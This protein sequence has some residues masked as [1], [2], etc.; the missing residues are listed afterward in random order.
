MQHPRSASNTT[1]RMRSLPPA[2]IRWR[3]TV[4][5][6]AFCINGVRKTIRMSFQ[7]VDQRFDLFL[8]CQPRGYLDSARL[9]CECVPKKLKG[10]P[11]KKIAQ[12]SRNNCEVNG[13]GSTQEWTNRTLIGHEPLMCS[14]MCLTR[15]ELVR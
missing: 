7:T 4:V 13:Q 12:K 2:T 3:Q 9:L 11:G 10:H 5:D 8:D 1:Q 6:Y 14:K 15:T